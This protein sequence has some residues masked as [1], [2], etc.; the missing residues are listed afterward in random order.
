MIGI[1]NAIGTSG[2]IIIFLSL[3][4]LIIIPTLCITGLKK[5]KVISKY[6]KTK[7]ALILVL[8]YIAILLFGHIT[9]ISLLQFGFFYSLTWLSILLLIGLVQNL[10]MNKKEYINKRKLTTKKC[11]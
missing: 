8:L 10:M 1:G 9:M 5:H 7:R 4:S 2:S 6:R 3:F 11:K